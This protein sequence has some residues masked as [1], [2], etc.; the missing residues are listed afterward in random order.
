[1][2]VDVRMV[3]S[4]NVDLVIPLERRKPS[5]SRTPDLPAGEA[6]PPLT[7]SLTRA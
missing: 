6:P 3:G 5:S 7:R 4:T 1:M 2:T